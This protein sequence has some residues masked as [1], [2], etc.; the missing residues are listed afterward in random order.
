MKHPKL[1]ISLI[2]ILLLLALAAV[3]CVPQQLTEQVA[4]P[5][6]ADTEPAPTEAATSVP[7]SATPTL[8]P[9]TSI[10][11]VALSTVASPALTYI[12]MKDPLTGWGLT[13]QKALRTTDGGATWQDITPTGGA[14]FNPGARGFFLD[15]QTAWVLV[16][17][18][19]FMSGTLYRTADGGVTWLPSSTPFG[20]AQLFFLDKN[21]GWALFV[22]SAGAGSAEA[23]VFQT[24]DGGQTWTEAFKME[25]GQPE[26][27]GG[28]PFAGMKNGL[29]FRDPLHG[30]VTGS[31]PMDGYA[32]LFAS[33]DG[34][35]AWQHLE[36]ALPKDYEKAMLSIDPPIFFGPQDGLLPVD[37][38]LDTSNKDF[39]VTHDAGST[40]TATAIVN[41][42]GLYDFPSLQDGWVWDGGANLSVT[43][44]GG[45]SYQTLTPNVDLS[46]VLGQLDF[47]DASTG[48][49]RTMD[50]NGA[51]KLYKTADG[52]TTWT[53][54]W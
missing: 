42:G 54:L 36:L 10:P 44:D 51:V 23:D 12:S 45:Q 47:V 52:G 26:A 41:H 37:L 11:T 33:Q 9:P 1:I 34:G 19:D 29:S 13:E 50:A 53:P 20:G 48:W 7:P 2:L 32:W 14:A 39:Y 15:A 3:A 21:T 8:P 30:W 31:E 6:P 16:P 4:S 24:A 35:H 40:W 5:S 28:L 25:P 22:P 38:Y 17:A 27:A 18:E 46:K 43:H 49:A